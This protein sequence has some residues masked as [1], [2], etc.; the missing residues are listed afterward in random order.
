MEG[1]RQEGRERSREI[2]RK[3][4][5]KET[6]CFSHGEKLTNLKYIEKCIISKLPQGKV[7]YNSL[8]EV[9]KGKYVYP[10]MARFL[11]R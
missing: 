7:F 6:S 11:C 3:T 5:R 1:W 9:K 8:T 10:G 2:G 4:G